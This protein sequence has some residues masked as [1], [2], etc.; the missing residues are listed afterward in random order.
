VGRTVEWFRSVPDEVSSAAIAN[1]PGRL[2]ATDG[3][4]LAAVAAGRSAAS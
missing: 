2:D 1:W 3:V 4:R